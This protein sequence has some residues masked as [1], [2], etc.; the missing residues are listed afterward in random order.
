MIPNISWDSKFLCFRIFLSFFSKNS[1]VDVMDKIIRT[2]RRRAPYSRKYHNKKTRH[3]QTT[4]GSLYCVWARAPEYEAW[5]RVNTMMRVNVGPTLPRN[6][7]LREYLTLCLHSV[8]YSVTLIILSFLENPIRKRC[9]PSFMNLPPSSRS[10]WSVK[11]SFSAT[12]TA[13][14]DK[15]KGTSASSSPL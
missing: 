10:T 11:S 2:Q 12:G 6:F 9:K 13:M 3:S 4:A 8:R 7:Y 14:S 15:I 1:F 5:I